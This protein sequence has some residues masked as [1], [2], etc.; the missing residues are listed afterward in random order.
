MTASISSQ[1]ISLFKNT[2]A[3]PGWVKLT[4]YDQYMLRVVD[5]TVTD[6]VGSPFSTVFTTS[7]VTG[8]V[9]ISGEVS[10]V[11]LT[12]AQ[13]PSHTHSMSGAYVSNT[14]TRV[15]TTT[16][17][18]VLMLEATTTSANSFTGLV[19]G[20]LAHTHS[21]SNISVNFTGTSLD[22]S[23]KYVDVIVAQRN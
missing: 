8:S 9:T 6:T 16:P 1:S 13:I 4:T 20:G 21:L 17:T 12:T 3:Q 7:P 5:S 23:I 15:S 19:G 10:N 2:T 14:L 18:N 11:T 22:F